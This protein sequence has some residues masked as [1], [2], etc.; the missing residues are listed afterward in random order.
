MGTMDCINIRLLVMLLVLWPGTGPWAHD[1]SL[2]VS[3]PSITVAPTGTHHFP[4]ISS[5]LDLASR[6]YV[7]KEYLISGTAQ[8]YINDGPFLANGV[9]NAFPNP[10]VPMP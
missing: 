4:Y 10:G 7:E 3:T 8:A 9:W 1:A 5:A 6:G 2:A